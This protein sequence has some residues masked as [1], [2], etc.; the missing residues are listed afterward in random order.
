M[1]DRAVI[2]HEQ[3]VHHRQQ[4]SLSSNARSNKVIVNLYQHVEKAESSLSAH[5]KHFT[6]VT[7][8][9]SNIGEAILQLQR[10]IEE[11][12][13]QWPSSSVV[14]SS[15]SAKYD[16]TA[17]EA[18]RADE[19][20]LQFL[21]KRFDQHG[22]SL[23]S[24]KARLEEMV[25]RLNF[26]SKFLKELIS[27]DTSITYNDARRS[28]PQ[29]AFP[30]LKSA[31]PAPPSTVSRADTGDAG[32]SPTNSSA[33]ASIAG[34]AA[35]LDPANWLDYVLATQRDATN[36]V[37]EANELKQL[38]E[39]DI[40]ALMRRQQS[41]RNDVVRQQGAAIY[42]KSQQRLKLQTET[43]MI[44][45]KLDETW[46][47]WRGTVATVKRMKKPMQS[48]EQKFHIRDDITDRVGAALTEEKE[49]LAKNRHEL[50]KL[51]RS[52]GEQAADLERQYNTLAAELKRVDQELARETKQQVTAER[53]TLLS[54]RHDPREDKQRAIR[55]FPTLGLTSKD[56]GMSSMS[57]SSSS[58][59]GG[60]GRWANGSFSDSRNPYAVSLSA[61]SGNP[62]AARREHGAGMYLPLP[63]A[64]ALD[65]IN[66][67]IAS[68][69][70]ARISAPMIPK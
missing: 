53:F 64:V 7:M 11:S 23:R 58:N 28:N 40:D 26:D 57:M 36:L 65:P 67:I 42:T 50:K 38:V 35:A 54:P 37:R 19:A 17:Q 62:N 24:V 5:K 48:S 20:A 29:G 49:D 63:P 69:Q 60:S 3:V 52:L 31:I 16:E 13:S 56:N 66:R 2:T 27:R 15:E 30:A 46:E 51:A 61:R 21:N 14:G 43:A 9:L 55:T 33:A 47:L 44:S 22:E 45:K 59:H 39:H 4:A 1:S 12:K 18:M 6:A 25:R 34:S 10:K 41:L 70:S 68:S 32:I 8:T